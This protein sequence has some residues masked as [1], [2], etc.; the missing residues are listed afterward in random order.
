MYLKKFNSI[1][2]TTFS[3]KLQTEGTKVPSFLLKKRMISKK[4]VENLV[5]Q[6]I[7]GTDIYIVDI[8]ISPSNKIIIELDKPEGILIADCLEISRH[9]E[10]GLDREI[11]DFELIVSSPGIDQPF[12]ILKQ[13]EKHIGKK[14][15][16]KTLDGKKLIGILKAASADEIKLIQEVK[17][18]IPGKTKKITVKKEYNIPFKEIKETKLVIKF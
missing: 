8:N 17:E 11:E 9:V 6:K 12:K 13:Y 3:S 16:S 1:F 18:K 2:A 14:V 10:R 5:K 4:I 15:I 7:E